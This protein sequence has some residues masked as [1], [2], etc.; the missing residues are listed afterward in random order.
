MKQ[1]EILQHMSHGAHL[2]YF[3][4]Y[5]EQPETL[6]LI[7]DDEVEHPDILWDNYDLQVGQLRSL[8]K[9]E[10]VY[11]SFSPNLWTHV[12]ILTPK[13][14]ILAKANQCYYGDRLRCVK[15]GS[16]IS[17]VNYSDCNN[18]WQK[19]TLGTSVEKPNPNKLPSAKLIQGALF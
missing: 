1:I 7:Y 10:L 16:H 17:S 12:H 18:P 6:S 15:C 9:K 14:N 5:Y 3:E 13:G 19:Q 11:E 8:V 2:T 4:P